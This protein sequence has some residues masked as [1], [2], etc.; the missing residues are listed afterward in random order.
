MCIHLFGV[1]GPLVALKRSMLERKKQAFAPG[2]HKNH[3]SQIRLYL[4]FCMKFN[5]QD[6][7]PSTETVCLYIEFLAQNLASPKAVA[8]YISAVRFL[9]KWLGHST[10]S[11]DSFEVTLLLRSCYAT[12]KHVPLQRRAM[13]PDMIRELLAVSQKCVLFTRCS[14]VQS[15]LHSMVFFEC[16]T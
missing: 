12:M 4:G 9:H 6:I 5:L 14:N 8:N 11:L 3:L 7:N 15:Y 10:E 1:S 2:T 13:S 16:Q